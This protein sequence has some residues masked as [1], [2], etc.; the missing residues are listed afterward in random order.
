MFI[1]SIPTTAPGPG[2]GCCFLC[3]SG[4]APQLL[5]ARE[6]MISGSCEGGFMDLSSIKDVCSHVPFVYTLNQI[7]VRANLLL[8][9]KLMR[10]DGQLP[11]WSPFSWP[12]SSNLG[13]LYL[14]LMNRLS[15]I[16][17]PFLAASYCPSDI[18]SKSLHAS[19]SCHVFNVSTAMS[20]SQPDGRPQ[21]HSPTPRDKT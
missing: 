14:R 12:P 11:G 16:N 5:K 1:L 3:R 21:I 15:E 20:D 17:S 2:V 9:M 6:M 10:I 4:V 13:A 7:L 18:L 19:V 8:Q